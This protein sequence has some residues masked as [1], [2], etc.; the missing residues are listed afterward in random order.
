MSRRITKWLQGR[1]SKRISSALWYIIYVML[2]ATAPVR[3]EIVHVDSADPINAIQLLDDW[4]KYLFRKIDIMGRLHCPQSDFCTLSSPTGF[5][6]VILVWLGIL[7]PFTKALVS[8]NCEKI[9]CSV[10]LRGFVGT[11]HFDVWD[12]VKIKVAET[13][14][15]KS[16]GPNKTGCVVSD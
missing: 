2:M 3:G 7:D 4:D 14:C 6:S 15:P 5:G 9:R 8:H 10:T 13:P 1:S 11:L 16:L 12:V